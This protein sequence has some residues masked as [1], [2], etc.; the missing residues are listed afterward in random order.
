MNR[1]PGVR[2]DQQRD[3]AE[4]QSADAE[5]HQHPPRKEHDPELAGRV[6]RRLVVGEVLVMLPGVPLVDRAQR[7]DARCI[8]YLCMAHSARLPA[9]KTGIIA[10]HSQVGSCRRL[11]QNA[12]AAIQ[13]CITA[14]M[15]QAAVDKGANWG[16]CL[17]PEPPLALAHHGSSPVD[18]GRR[19][20]THNNILDNRSGTRETDC[21]SAAPGTS[22][23]ILALVGASVVGTEVGRRPLRAAAMRRSNCSRRTSPADIWQGRGS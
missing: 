7:E 22:V 16:L 9:R 5:H 3:P 10:S 11:T 2:I 20:L 17:L 13:A 19:P 21:P 12:I 14:D 4:P 8:T 15:E 23:H 6:D 18:R 1:T